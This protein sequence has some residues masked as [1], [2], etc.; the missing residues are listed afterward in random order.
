MPAGAIPSAAPS[1]SGVIHERS[2]PYFSRCSLSSST[3]ISASGYGRLPVSTVAISYI[4]SYFS[5]DNDL[6]V[7]ARLV[8]AVR[9]IV[10]PHKPTTTLMHN[11]LLVQLE[12]GETSCSA[13]S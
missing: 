2:T 5:V 6:D 9:R 13:A 3:S 1:I 4:T 10:R 12:D 11:A 8:I 7:S